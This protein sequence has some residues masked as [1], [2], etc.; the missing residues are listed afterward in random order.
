MGGV[1]PVGRSARTTSYVPVF[2]FY[3]VLPPRDVSSTTPADANP[4]G[5]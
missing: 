5:L 3:P 4:D 2:V 1:P